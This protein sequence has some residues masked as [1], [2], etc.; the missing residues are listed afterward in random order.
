MPRD[1]ERPGDTNSN[2]G[3]PADLTPSNTPPLPRS[4]TH[5]ERCRTLAEEARVATLATIARDPDGFPY[6]SLVTVA[7]DTAGRPL[8][9]LSRLAEHTQN[10]ERRSDASIL[11]T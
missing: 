8:L 5:A 6:A 3:D 2:A 4:P 10:L 1:H 7:M 9:L 11:L